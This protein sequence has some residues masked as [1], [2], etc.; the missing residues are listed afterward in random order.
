MTKAP[1]F[2]EAELRRATKVAAA[3]GFCVIVEKEPGKVRLR[4]E[5]LWVDPQ[6]D[7]DGQEG[8]KPWPKD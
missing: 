2:T 1:T 5:P 6:N 3:T 7:S 4:M 8:P